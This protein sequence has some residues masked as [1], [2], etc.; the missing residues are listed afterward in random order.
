MRARALVGAAITGIGAHRPALRPDNLAIAERIGSS[1]D[2]IRERSGI[3]TRGAAGPEET[4]VEMGVMAAGKALAAAGVDASQV[5][6]VLLAT[7]TMPGPLPGGA[8]EIAARLG[9]AAAGA[10]DIGAGCAGFTYGISLA[11]DT[12]RA[13]TAEHVLVIGSERLLDL[14]DH[15]DR[16]TA[17]LFGDGGGAAVVSRSAVDAIGP[18]VWAHDG[19]QH[20]RLTI[21]GTPPRLAMEGRAIYRW[22]TTSLPGLCRRA[23]AE[24][25]LEL[26]D[27]AA[28]VPHQANLRITESVVATLGL[29]PEVVVARDIVDSGNTSAASVPLAL[30]RLLELGEVGSGDA[31]LLAG[32]GAGLTAAAQVVLVP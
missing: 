29:G 27:L 19:E 22:A 6:L 2:W 26:S 3:V 7:C 10:T 8:P 21:H 12:V 5:G 28:F 18:V 4:V 15:D 23:V 30:A 14:V 32:F 25:D 16:G 9:A 1:D 31:V 17:F 11:A 13:G 24:A 20:A